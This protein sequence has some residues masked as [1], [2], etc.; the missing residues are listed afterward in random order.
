MSA[1]DKEFEQLL[2]EAR[3]LVR[4]HVEA[5]PGVRLYPDVERVDSVIEGLARRKQRFGDF[6]CP[7]RI[8]TGDVEKDASIVCPCPSGLEEVAEQGYCKCHL[9]ASTEVELECEKP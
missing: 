2:A 6:Y 5:H 9:F 8:M 4:R 1:Q 7:C 3:A